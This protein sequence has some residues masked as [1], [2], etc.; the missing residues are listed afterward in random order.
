MDLTF[1]ILSYLLFI[2]LT[3]SFGYMSKIF[4]LDI[5]PPL[6]G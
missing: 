2:E 5:F 3:S 1:T 4:F 6:E